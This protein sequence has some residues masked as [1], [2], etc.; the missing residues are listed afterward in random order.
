MLRFVFGTFGSLV[1]RKADVELSSLRTTS[2]VGCF[3]F[4]PTAMT[5]FPVILTSHLGHLCHVVSD[6][7][8]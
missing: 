5:D 1:G 6:K 7:A 3:R 4:L 8:L 2:N